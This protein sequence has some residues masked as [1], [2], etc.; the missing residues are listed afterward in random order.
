MHTTTNKN[1]RESVSFEGITSSINDLLAYGR[2]NPDK[3]RTKIKK[4]PKKRIFLLGHINSLK[5][6][7]KETL[8]LFM[9]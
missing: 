2:T 3:L 8:F 4:R 1:V 9:R 6:H 7:L 5:A